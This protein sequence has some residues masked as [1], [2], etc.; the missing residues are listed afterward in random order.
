MAARDDGA[1]TISFGHCEREAMGLQRA[2]AV[3]LRYFF[4]GLAL[5]L[6]DDFGLVAGLALLPDL[7]PH[8]LHI[9]APFQ[10]QPGSA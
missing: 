7:H 8:V 1:N 5:L 9:L 3:P 6:F 4:L 2:S 10:K